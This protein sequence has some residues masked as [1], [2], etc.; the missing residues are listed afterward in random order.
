MY[1]LGTT[2]CNVF[3]VGQ[4][5]SVQIWKKGLAVTHCLV[6]HGLPQHWQREAWSTLRTAV[7][8][9]MVS[10]YMVW[11]LVLCL[12]ACNEIALFPAKS[13]FRESLWRWRWLCLTIYSS[14]QWTIVKD[15]MLACRSRYFILFLQIYEDFFKYVCS[16]KF[17]YFVCYLSN[18]TI[19]ILVNQWLQGISIN[20]LL[21]LKKGRNLIKVK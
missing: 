21:G 11:D 16:G 2:Y 1:Q 8:L 15:V 6:I 19:L 12:M 9:G 3:H 5:I 13:V 20:I 18:I 4:D 17:V 14:S 10:F 7:W